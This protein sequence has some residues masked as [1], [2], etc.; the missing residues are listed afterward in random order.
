MHEIKKEKE[1]GI[2]SKQTWIK[3]ELNKNEIRVSK[4]EFRDG[5]YL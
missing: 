3:K 4:I 1:L 2:K 5:I